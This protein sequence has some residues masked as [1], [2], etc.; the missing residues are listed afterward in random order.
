MSEFEKE[1]GKELGK[2]LGKEAGKTGKDIYND[3]GKPLL[4]E[5]G[6][7]LAKP[8]RAVNSILTEIGNRHTP[9]YVVDK[10]ESIVALVKSKL[11]SKDPKKIV[12]PDPYVAVPALQA[13]SYSMNNEELR[14][15]YAN[16]LASSM[17]SD[18]KSD[19][20][21]AFTEIIKQLCP[22][23]VKLIERLRLKSVLPVVSLI[24]KIKENGGMVKVGK[25]M[26]E[27][28]QENKC[29]NFLK[30][31]E[32]LENLERLKIINISY[33]SFLFKEQSYEY[34][35]N[36]EQIKEYIDNTHKLFVPE[37]K[38]GFI[39]MTEFGKNF[40]KICCN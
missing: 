35:Y 6:E 17:N 3:L 15:L 31:P 26:I 8:V 33:D 20:H 5:T 19:V 29:D 23:E 4:K 38:K 7:L 27:P 30:V 34:F 39:E 24:L 16:L 13:I 32:Y 25:H 40:V 10:L 22:D 28:Y 36:D 21:P 11:S 12:S 18:T 9:T 1:F 37:L 14:S 2:N